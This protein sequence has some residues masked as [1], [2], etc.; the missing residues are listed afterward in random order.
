[1]M[2]IRPDQMAAFEQD[3]LAKF[4]TRALAH[5]RGPLADITAGQSDE[6]LRSRVRS[7]ILHARRYGLTTE[8]EVIALLD[9]SF[10][11]GDE[12]FDANPA[13]HW[14]AEL[15]ADERYTPREKAALLLDRSFDINANQPARG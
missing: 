8:Q 13:H 2:I 14:A 7:S 1:M 6:A 12:A 11:L 3:A 10:F 9:A 15:L 4:E 5:L